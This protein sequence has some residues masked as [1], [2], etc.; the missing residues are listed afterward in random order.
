MN[1][2]IWGYKMWCFLINLVNYQDEF[3]YIITRRFELFFNQLAYVLPCNA[4]KIHYMNFIKIHP[5]SA[6]SKTDLLIWLCNVYNNSVPIT[7][8]KNINE[9]LEKGNNYKIEYFWD[10][11][12]YIAKEYSNN[13]HENQI[14]YKQFFQYL[15]DINGISEKIKYIPIEPYLLNSKLLTNYIN[16]LKDNS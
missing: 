3:N 4:C 13:K 5:V 9:F 8:R 6:N 11:L 12:L 10:T 1:P 7:K 2:N 15:F 14:A 16:I